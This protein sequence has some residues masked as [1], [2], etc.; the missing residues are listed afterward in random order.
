MQKLHQTDMLSHFNGGDGM[1]IGIIGAG[2]AALS[3]NILLLILTLTPLRAFITE[4]TKRQLRQ[5]IFVTP[6]RLIRW[7]NW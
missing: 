2:R 6:Q 7:R 1:K 3:A 5:P 4:V